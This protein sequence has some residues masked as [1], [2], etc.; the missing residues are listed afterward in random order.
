MLKVH[1]VHVGGHGYYLEGREQGTELEWP[2][3]WAGPAS[4]DLG[5][6]GTVEQGEFDGVMAGADPRT[7]EVLRAGRGERGVSAFDLTFCAPKSVSLL[8]A[9]AP[10]E[11]AEAAGEGHHRAV[12]D[13][14]DYLSHHGIGVRRSHR[15]SVELLPSTGMVAGEFRHRVSRALDPHLHTHLVAANLARGPDGAWSSIDGR[16]LFAHLRAAGGLYHA[17]LRL[18]LTQRL[19]AAWEVRPSG[20]GDVV[21]VDPVL[22]RLFSQRTAAIDEFVA[23]RRGGRSGRTEGAALATRPGKE[24]DG[25]LASLTATWRRRAA[26]L[27]LDLGE[28]S[29]VVGRCRAVPD[30]AVPGR[31]DPDRLAAALSRAGRPDAVLARRD[32]VAVVSASSV[33]GAEGRT[34]AAVVDRIAGSVPVD[35]T[36]ARA[37]EPRWRA[38]DVEHLARRDG[39]RLVRALGGRTDA[40]RRR[41]SVDRRDDRRRTVEARRGRSV[42]DGLGR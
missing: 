31:P 11:V 27:G 2:G 16:R 37:R 3:R 29:R 18:E 12:A 7:G 24:L 10:R 26:D 13:A 20:M 42:D 39:D 22:R 33:A 41:P 19:G 35:R 34:V 1:V 38:G 25:S 17:R 30:P 40:D 15:G 9:L 36:L 5:L 28:L 6:G 8:H 32:L 21:G 23:T 4:A 14:A